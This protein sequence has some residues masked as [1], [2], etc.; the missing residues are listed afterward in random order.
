[1]EGVGTLAGTGTAIRTG[2][3]KVTDDLGRLRLRSGIPP[4]HIM[5][6]GLIT[7]CRPP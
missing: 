3:N 1:M 6:R 7:L 5:G 4:A 2:K